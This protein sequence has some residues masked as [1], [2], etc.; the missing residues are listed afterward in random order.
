MVKQEGGLLQLELCRAS[1]LC[2]YLSERAWLCIS[3]TNTSFQVLSSSRA[4][5]QATLY[6]VCV[7]EMGMLQLSHKAMYSVHVSQ[8]VQEVKLLCAV[9]SPTA[10][11]WTGF[12]A[13]VKPSYLSADLRNEPGCLFLV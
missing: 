12:H 2:V 11:L 6:T 4:S 1:L 9:S 10:R 13:C 3:K 5:C 8:D 7:L